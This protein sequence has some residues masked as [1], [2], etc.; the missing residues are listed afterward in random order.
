M[1]NWTLG[2]YPGGNLELLKQPKEKLAIEK[3]G[4]A[5]KAAPHL[6]MD[7]TSLTRKLKKHS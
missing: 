3:Y 2:G 5:R 1:L 4:S 7:S 6:G